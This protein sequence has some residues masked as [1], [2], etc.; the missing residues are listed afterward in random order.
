[1]A[2]VYGI[3][4]L[5]YTT[6]TQ[7]FVSGYGFS[8]S[9]SGL[10]FLGV[11]IGMM[12]GLVTFGIMSNKLLRKLSIDGVMKPE[13][14]LPLMIPAAAL[15]PIGLFI[16]GWTAQNLVH[17]IVPITGTALVG[18]GSIGTFVSQIQI[19]QPSHFY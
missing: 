19:V 7:V 11:G 13:Y 17:W 5:L 16:Y 1:M 3:I 14:R 8:P 6:I 12:S 10:A 2:F 9:I 18:M 15:A 4:Y